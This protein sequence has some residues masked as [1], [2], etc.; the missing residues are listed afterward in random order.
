MLINELEGNAPQKVIA[1]V[2]LTCEE[3]FVLENE[4]GNVVH[5]GDSEGPK[6]RAFPRRLAVCGAWIHVMSVGRGRHWRDV[7]SFIHKGTLLRLSLDGS[8]IALVSRLPS[9]VLFPTKEWEAF[10]R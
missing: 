8:T 2:C 9:S 4:E 5:R 7:F 3:E 1:D 6:V 10:F